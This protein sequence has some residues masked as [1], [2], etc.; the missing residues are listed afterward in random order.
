MKS[1]KTYTK[2][3]I[4]LV[5]CMAIYSCGITEMDNK[6]YEGKTVAAFKFQDDQVDAGSG[7]IELEVQV[8][9]PQAGKLTEALDISYEI[10]GDETTAA[11]PA[12]YTFITP[13]PLTIQAD[14]LRTKLVIDVD[15]SAIPD[16]EAR[17]L[18]IKLTGNQEKG[19]TG[20][21]IIGKFELTIE[22]N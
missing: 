7:Q 12:D 5:L 1:F 10:V 17:V 20:A 21:D 3:L 6:V 2:S 4:M 14:S 9:R 11:S 16:G 8:I 15:G 18:T 19:V 22:G 13:S